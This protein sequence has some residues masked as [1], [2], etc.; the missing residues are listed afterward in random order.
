MSNNTKIK[1]PFYSTAKWVKLRTAYIAEFPLCEACTKKG[2]VRATTEIDHIIA[3][4]IDWDKRLDWDNL[5][6]LCHSCH[7]KKTK[8]VDERVLQGL[9]AKSWQGVGTDGIPIDSEYWQ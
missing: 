2:T 3:I 9:S 5:M 7:M 6:A 8:S 4:R 1:N